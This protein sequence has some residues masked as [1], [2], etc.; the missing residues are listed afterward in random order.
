M[1]RRFARLYGD[2]SLGVET[3]GLDLDDARK[4][5]AG[6][7]DDDDTE[8]VEVELRIVA[9]HGKPKI[10]MVR[11]RRVT[12]PTCAEKIWLDENLEVSV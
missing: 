5:L 7:T 3:P 1:S 2:G 8:I 4:R 9:S 12:C 11:Q 10:K 6:S